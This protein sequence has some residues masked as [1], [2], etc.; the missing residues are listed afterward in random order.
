M[1]KLNASWVGFMSSTFMSFNTK[2]I[3]ENTLNLARSLRSEEYATPSREQEYGLLL[4]QSK[5]F[6]PSS[7][8]CTRSRTKWATSETRVWDSAKWVS[9]ECSHCSW[10]L[11]ISTASRTSFLM[12]GVEGVGEEE[13]VIKIVECG[14]RG[15]SEMDYDGI[16]ALTSV[17]MIDSIV[18][19]QEPET[20]SS[21]SVVLS[22]QPNEFKSSI[23]YS[24][25]SNPLKYNL[26]FTQA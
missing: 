15:Y 3:S 12:R 23:L 13:E 11:R 17:G 2:S 10:V 22:N 26:L 21:S 7:T 1:T 5:N 6:K 4:A 24:D 16:K 8:L 18:K 25:N 9:R 19:I 14:S 20:H